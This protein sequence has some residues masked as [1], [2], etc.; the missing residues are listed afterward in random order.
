MKNMGHLPYWPRVLRREEAADYIGVSLSLFDQKAAEEGFPRRVRVL[1][2]VE[3]YR[4]DDVDRWLAGRP[5][6]HGEIPNP[7]DD[8]R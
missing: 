8:V 6:A 4:R 1:G 5:Q 3:G 2:T 7:W